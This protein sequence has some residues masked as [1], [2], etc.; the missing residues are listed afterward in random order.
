MTVPGTL[1]EVQTWGLDNGFP[2]PGN[3]SLSNAL[4]YNVCPR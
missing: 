3:S 1:I 4:E 2:S